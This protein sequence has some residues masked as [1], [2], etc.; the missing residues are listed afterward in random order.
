M[1]KRNRGGKRSG[2]GQTT[3]PPP[4]TPNQPPQGRGISP[5]SVGSFGL[6]GGVPQK[7]TLTNGS[8]LEANWNPGFDNNGD[9]NVAKWQAQEDDK[10]ARFLSKIDKDYTFSNGKYYDKNGNEISDQFGFYDDES[11][12]FSMAL[13]LNGKPQVMDDAAFDAMVAQNKLQRI[14]RGES[15]Q[16]AADRF[17]NADIGHVG[18]GSFGAGYYFS[19]DKGV[20]IDYARDKS[21]YTGTGKVETM[22]LSPTAHAIKLSDLK[23]RMAGMSGR[24]QRAMEIA[25]HGNTSPYKNQGYAQ[26]A[27]KLGYNVI[28]IDR[29]YGTYF[30]AVDRSAFIVRRSLETY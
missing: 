3:V 7:G 28:A 5:N 1:P 14:Y 17:Y 24:L 19:T 10:A 23:A 9:P 18:A 20:A 16:N 13:N 21:N 8:Q 27:V 30:V 2:S 11:Q 22:V 15:G 26:A 4:T 12:K 29:G 25:G 6:P